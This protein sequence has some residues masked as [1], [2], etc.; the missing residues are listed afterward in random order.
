MRPY[1]EAWIA[2]RSDNAFSPTEIEIRLH[3]GRFQGKLDRVGYI[4]DKLYI[5]DIKTP[6]ALPVSAKLQLAAYEILLRFYR[7]SPKGG[8]LVQS[9]KPMRIYR[10]AVWLLP[11]GKFKEPDYEDKCDKNTFLNAFACFQWQRNNN[12]FKGR[13][14]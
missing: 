2:F 11:T 5:I 4:K 3:N 14:S 1:L 8:W 6:S 12:L 7:R 10:K 13:E 9:H